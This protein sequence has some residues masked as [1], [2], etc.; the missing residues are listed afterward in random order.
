MK[1]LE[2][3][4]YDYS[5]KYQRKKP[6]SVKIFCGDALCKY[7]LLKNM[8]FDAITLIEL[9]E[10]IEFE[11]LNRL[12]QNVFGFLKAPLVIITT[13]NYDFNYFFTQNS[14]YNNINCFFINFFI[15]KGPVLEILIINLNLQDKNS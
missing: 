12:E 8:N 1:N 5:L 14:L 2:P 3:D 4:I 6:L 15:E 13:P 9:I 10:H 11:Q 7:E